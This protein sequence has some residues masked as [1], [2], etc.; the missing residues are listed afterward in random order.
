MHPLPHLISGF[1][2]EG[3]RQDA[4][5]G[6][7]VRLD[8]MRYAMRDYARL[9]ATGAGED[10]QGS[11]GGLDRAPLRLVEAGEQI[12][13]VQCAQLKRALVGAA[14]TAPPGMDSGAGAEAGAEVGARTETAL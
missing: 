11:V 7:M 5:S 2:G 14:G 1:I 9:A 8:Q 13:D 12:G 6:N 3:D 4:G 10:Q